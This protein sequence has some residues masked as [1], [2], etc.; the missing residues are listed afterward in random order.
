[1]TLQ[2][3]SAMTVYDLVDKYEALVELRRQRD[4]LLAQGQR[5]FVGE[6][7]GLRRAALRR[8]AARFPGALRELESDPRTLAGRLALLQHGLRTTPRVSPPQ[9]AVL[10]LQYHLFLREALAI[11]R[12]LSQKRQ[13][14]PA[15][16][17][18][19][20]DFSAW[21]ACCEERVRPLSAASDL[22]LRYQRPPGGRISEL[23]LQELACGSGWTPDK[24]R[25]V[26]F[27]GED[28][29]G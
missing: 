19:R 6:A 10:S 24:L 23:V 4:A 18:L 1:M 17:Q 2:V 26:L 3:A 20:D 15:A 27:G 11:K 5:R 16:A 29:D 7:A 8:L 21:F 12:W 28:E 9:W 13:R 22:L 25:S 14:M